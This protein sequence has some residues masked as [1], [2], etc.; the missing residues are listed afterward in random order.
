MKRQLNRDIENLAQEAI[1]DHV[2][3]W[4]AIRTHLEAAEQPLSKSATKL[5]EEES[6]MVWESSSLWPLFRSEQGKQQR[7]MQ[8]ALFLSLI[9]VIALGG[10]ISLFAL[11]QSSNILGWLQQAQAPQATVEAAPEPI[12]VDA[13]ETTVISQTYQSPGI[14]IETDEGVD[15][16]LFDNPFN[17]IPLPFPRWTDPAWSPDGQRIAYVFVNSRNEF[18][19][20][21]AG[22]VQTIKMPTPYV[23]ALYPVWS[24]DGTRI[25]I[26]SKANKKY[27]IYIVNYDG[28]NLRPL[29]SNFDDSI[30]SPIWSPDGQKIAFFVGQS[31]SSFPTLN[32]GTDIYVI[33]ADGT[34]LT[35]LTDDLDID[36]M[37]ITWSPDSRRIAYVSSKSETGRT[38]YLS[39]INIDGTDKVNLTEDKGGISPFS[40][41]WSP[42]AEK[43]IFSSIGKDEIDSISGSIYTIGSDG[44]NLTRLTDE[45]FSAMFPSLSPN[46]ERIVFW[47]STNYQEGELYVMDVDG[48]N[49]KQLSD[50]LP[51]YSIFPKWIGWLPPVADLFLPVDYTLKNTPKLEEASLYTVVP[52]DQLVLQ[53]GDF[54][55]ATR[56]LPNSGRILIAS[57][58]E[59]DIVDDYSVLVHV[60]IMGH[61]KLVSQPLLNHVYRFESAEHAATQWELVVES[62]REE[63]LGEI[64]LDETSSTTAYPSR[65]F[66]AKTVGE[67]KQLVYWGLILNNDIINIMMLSDYWATTGEPNP[68]SPERFIDLLE[69]AQQKMDAYAASTDPGWQYIEETELT[70]PL[71]LSQTMTDVTVTVDQAY[72]DANRIAVDYTVAITGQRDFRPLDVKLTWLPD[73][74][75]PR[76]T[77][78]GDGTGRY[79]LSFDATAIQT[80]ARQLDL[81]LEIYTTEFVYPPELKRLI[82]QYGSIEQIPRDKLM[83][84]P[85]ITK[86]ERVGPFSFDFSIPFLPSQTLSPQQSTEVRRIKILL[87]EMVITP[88]Q[89]QATLCATPLSN[90]GA[91]TD[92]TPITTLKTNQGELM[93]SGAATVLRQTDQEI[94]YRLTFPYP[95]ADQSGQW[96]LTVTELVG[97][98]SIVD[99]KQLRLGGPWVFQ[100]D[101]P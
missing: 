75:L 65:M 8:P 96:T 17:P 3:L 22:S 54:S 83:G 76:T 33:N 25:A 93:S 56:R 2:D 32:T 7:T 72:A 20:M 42:N 78:H 62:L 24:P 13:T 21:K 69:I 87:E 88:S 34:G 66:T 55:G 84:Q 23:D 53:K 60:P 86:G 12:E 10:I 27:Q 89:T 39:V 80:T 18:H 101:V 29:G 5:S 92:W 90:D 100:I 77:G 71:K 15:V 35:R 99:D 47:S 57:L 44:T 28:T 49:L 38:S 67:S 4:P 59:A 1:P 68:N 51:I 98:H 48:S 14:F 63:S 61:K 73:T 52:L 95:L 45:S 46:G 64:L 36:P 11:E 58:P 16:L 50:T 70:E 26:M 37:G 82:G 91:F 79:N 43:I 85:D 30:Q 81:Q 40:P 31:D 6:T 97:F 74:E 9:L 94:C 19:I 41:M